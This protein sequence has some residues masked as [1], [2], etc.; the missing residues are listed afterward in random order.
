M[1][2][3]S[4][5]FLQIVSL[6]DYVYLSSGWRQGKHLSQ[7]FGLAVELNYTNV[8]KPLRKGDRKKYNCPEKQEHT[9]V[10]VGNMYVKNIIV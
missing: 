4:G 6:N 5:N 7:H 10:T 3:P 1:F 9:A 2:Q 8:L